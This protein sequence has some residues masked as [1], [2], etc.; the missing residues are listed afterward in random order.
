MFEYRLAFISLNLL[1]VFVLLCKI[2]NRQLDY[3]MKR[4]GTLF[5][6]S[7]VTLALSAQGQVQFLAKAN[8][9]KVVKGGT[10]EVKFVLKNSNGEDFEP[11][12]FR[13][14]EVLSGPSTVMNKTFVNGRLSQ[15]VTYAYQIKALRVGQF[16]IEKARIKVG[17]RHF[18]TAPL[19]I[20]VVK[21][22][23][24]TAGEQPIF[25]QPKFDTLA[26]IGQQVEVTYYLYSTQTLLD[27]NV[28]STP[29][30]SG[31][32]TLPINFF[33]LDEQIEIINGRQYIMKPI[34]KFAV[35][36]QRD[37][38]VSIDELTAQVKVLDKSGNFPRVIEA[39]VISESATLRVNKL[40]SIPEYFMGGV[41]RFNFDATLIK[42]E[43]STDDNTTLTL[44]IIGTGDI[45]AIQVPDLK[46]LK[47]YF[48][49][50][51]PAINSQSEEQNDVII[52][53]KVM[54]FQLVP[55]KTGTFQ[56]VPMFTYF[57]TES[58]QFKTIKADTFDIEIRQGKN[59]P[60]KDTKGNSSNDG[61][62]DIK[63][64]LTSISFK[65]RAKLF[66]S[67]LFWILLTAPFLGFII[68][69]FL[70]KRQSN[71][72][73]RDATLGK[74]NQADRIALEHLAKAKTHLK[75]GEEKVFYNEINKAL[76]GYVS[77]K[78][79]MRRAELSKDN[80]RSKLSQN[81][82]AKK[83]IDEFIAL[84]NDC[85]MAVFAGIGG[86]EVAMQNTYKQAVAIIIALENKAK[87]DKA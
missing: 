77:N 32:Y 66:G 37:G 83:Q 81:G 34:R 31:T 38:A 55:K 58:K 45:N 46:Q 63:P 56:Y 9:E 2:D 39:E 59:K 52:S 30:F 25:I 28:L 49:V 57:D 23:S 68:A 44:D 61:V 36:P 22:A 17:N 62:R 76:W 67:P 27:I 13:D 69:V 18:Y 75:K 80:I 29:K 12:S 41:G 6:L 54:T 74:T 87:N 48:E 85:E 50:Y 5:L 21:A 79:V 20:E 19:S 84:L 70:K 82:I 43:L 53:R 7:F 42:E 1:R 4:L 64:N 71:K 11:P 10:L 73:Q 35:F 78:L 3:P 72:E 65:T 14:F 15:S 26:Y 33:T 16:T 47:T 40:D 8:A 60:Q 86:D 51:D 24:S